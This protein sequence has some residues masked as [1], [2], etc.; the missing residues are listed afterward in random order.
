MY[1]NSTTPSSNHYITPSSQHAT[2]SLSKNA[3]TTNLFCPYC[4]SYSMYAP[5]VAPHYP[6]IPFLCYIHRPSSIITSSVLSSL[7]PPQAHAHSSIM[8]SGHMRDRR[9][10]C[11]NQEKRKSRKDISI[12]ERENQDLVEVSAYRS[13]DE[14]GQHE[15]CSNFFQKT[16]HC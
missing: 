14:Q 7:F 10:L 15:E 6:H 12:R 5:Y 2:S 13:Q 8:M 1:N 16:N 9:N 3:T 4:T 11:Y